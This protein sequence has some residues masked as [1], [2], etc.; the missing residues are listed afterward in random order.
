MGDFQPAT[1]EGS[2]GSGPSV[3]FCD[4]TLRDG[5]QMPGVAF[6]LSSRIEIAQEL[7]ALGVDEIEVGFACAGAAC[8]DIAAVADL[9]LRAHILVLCRPLAVD[10]AAA[11][12]AGVDG[13]KLV[14]TVSPIHLRHKFERPGADV[15]REACA[16]VHWARA[17]GL[18]TQLS[19]EDATRSPI[20]DLVEAAQAAV[21]A[22][23]QC[24]SLA[25]TVGV[26]TPALMRAIAARV[27]NAVDVPVTAHCHNDFG[28]AVANSLA[29]VD[30]GARV[31]STTVNGI[32][33]RSGNASTVDC[34][35]A[36]ERLYGIKTS[37]D[38]R[39][40]RR[41]SVLVASHSG[42]RVPAH[43]PIVGENCFRHESGIHVAAILRDP[44]CYEPYD[45]ELVGAERQLVLGKT[46]GRAAVRYVA[47]RLGMT[48]DEDDCRAIL[49]ELKLRTE[50][51]DAVDGAEI[52]RS[53][54]GGAL[55]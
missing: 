48:L 46:S 36:L 15:V 23:A 52:I 16:A 22:G 2:G 17:A 51:G 18:V 20:E 4:S 6:S 11:V 55:L 44:S 21:A 8:A 1:V 19:F 41:T 42:V 10:I 39:R 28:L 9:G 47:E 37:L 31:L 35:L 13:V 53:V 26:A 49:R 29:A 30:G 25:D 3:R 33:E 12:E 32:G 50:S 40:L 5:E 43:S 24:I 38:L 27:V 7:D 34:A 14:T 45:P 54:A